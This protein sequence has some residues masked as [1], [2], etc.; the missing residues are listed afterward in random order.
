MTVRSTTYSP[1]LDRQQ[2]RDTDMLSSMSYFE[3]ERGKMHRGGRQGICL[4]I[5]KRDSLD[6]SSTPCRTLR[7]PGNMVEYSPYFVVNAIKGIKWSD[8]GSSEQ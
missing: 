1:A 8:E 3:D 4:S 6:T 2:S 7:E 5:C